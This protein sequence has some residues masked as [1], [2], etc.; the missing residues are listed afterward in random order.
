MGDSAQSSENHRAKRNVD[1]K[2]Q[3]QEVSVG[4]DNSTGIGLQAMCVTPDK[5]CLHF[6]HVLRFC[7]SLR[8]TVMTNYSC[9]WKFKAAQYLVCWMLLN[10][11]P[12]WKS[13][14]KSRCKNF[15]FHQKESTCKF[16]AIES[17]VS[18]NISIRKKPSALHQDNEK[19]GLKAS[20]ETARSN[21]HTLE[22]VEVQTFPLRRQAQGDQLIQQ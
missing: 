4:S 8:F 7:W 15:T 3:V 22:C 10:A 9:G 18:E 12:Q 2:G 17:I 1:S 13:G 19:E 14:A 5:K 6:A 11:H 20:Q 21:K 16:G